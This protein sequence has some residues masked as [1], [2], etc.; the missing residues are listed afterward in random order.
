MFSGVLERLPQLCKSA[1]ECLEGAL[2][3]WRQPA[4]RIERRVAAFVVA[5]HDP[6]APGAA[7]V[8]SRGERDDEHLVEGYEVARACQKTFDARRVAVVRGVELERIAV[9][10]SVCQQRDRRGEPL[11]QQL[12]PRRGIGIEPSHLSPGQ[13]RRWPFQLSL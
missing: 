8:V 7:R 3:L 12:L 5:E 11:A 4:R 2:V 9:V 6:H 10:V 13:V 1:W